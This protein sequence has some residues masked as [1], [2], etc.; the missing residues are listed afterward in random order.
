MDAELKLGHG[1]EPTTTQG[2][3]IN[4]RAAEKVPIQ[5]TNVTVNKHTHTQIKM[6]GLM[7]LISCC[8]FQ[9]ENQ[10]AD[11]VAQG[12]V[13]VRGGKRLEGSFMQPTLLSNV[14]TDMLCMREETFG[15]LIPV[16]K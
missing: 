8:F 10:I 12:A 3:L 14:D 4:V 6:I 15:P 9:V 5:Y 11:A 7:V 13:I 2:P 16:V 1:S